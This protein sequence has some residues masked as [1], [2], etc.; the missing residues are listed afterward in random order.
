MRDEELV[1]FFAGL[2]LVG[3]LSSGK[4]EPEATE[5]QIAKKSFSLA[6]AMIEERKRRNAKERL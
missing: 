6:D 5:K 4:V 2:V 1:D 3:L